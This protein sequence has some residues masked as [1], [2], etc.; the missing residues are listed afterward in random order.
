MS[1]TIPEQAIQQFSQHLNDGDI[2][3]PWPSTSPTLP[4]FPN[5]ARPSTASTPSARR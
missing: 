5:P 2:E 3:G 4:S 1:A